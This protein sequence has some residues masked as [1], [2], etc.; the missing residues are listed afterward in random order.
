MVGGRGLRLSSECA[1]REPE[2]FVAV[3]V[4]GGT[5]GERAEAWVRRASIVDRAWLDPERVVCAETVAFDQASASVRGTRRTTY[6]DLVLEDVAIQ[7]SRG[8]AV[9]A[10]LVGAAR[11]DLESA[12]ALDDPAVSGLR[13]RVE[14]LRTWHPDLALPPM[15]TDALI[16]L[17]PSLAKGCRSFAELRKAPLADHLRGA[18]TYEQSQVLAREAPEAIEVPSG[19]RIR[20]KYEAGRPPILAVRIQEAFGLRET[21]TVAG[22]RVKVLMHLLAPNRRPQQITDDLPSFWANTYAGVRGELRRRYPKHSWPED[23][24]TAKAERRPRRRR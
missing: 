13:L 8:P 19:N 7:V 15:D 9:E 16:A 21:P 2:L 4:D 14:S 22:G 10:A 11:D 3:D 12:L 6:D 5:K 20:L 24:Y 18:F 17:L 1:V 23:P